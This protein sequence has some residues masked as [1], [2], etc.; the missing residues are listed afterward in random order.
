[1]RGVTSE[2]G[3][4]M[5]SCIISALVLLSVL[6]SLN[7][8]ISVQR[9]SAVTGGLKTTRSFSATVNSGDRDYDVD[10]DRL[11]EVAN[12]AQLDAMRYDLDGDG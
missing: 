11:I 8:P 3:R 1:M 9:T 12:L 5:N 10:N 2:N 7:G 4:H 6:T